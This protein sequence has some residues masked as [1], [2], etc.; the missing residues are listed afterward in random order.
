MKTIIKWIL[1]GIIILMI[2]QC[3]TNTKQQQ[4][5]SNAVVQV[6]EI[7][8]Y[9]IG[10]PLD[11]EIEDQKK[12]DIIFSAIAIYE[13]DINRDGIK[14]KIILD[15]LDR[16]NDPGDFHR[17]RIEFKDT[18]YHFYNSSGW[19]E[20]N[21]SFADE[22]IRDLTSINKIKSD[23]VILNENNNNLLLFVFGYVY[24]SSPGLLTIINL[25]M[26]EPQLILNENY[27]L[28]KYQDTS[29]IFIMSKFFKEDHINKY[30]T[31]ILKGRWLL[32]YSE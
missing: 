19:V 24:A 2:L 13:Y 28:V 29:P 17:V 25:S 6:D 9:L 14:E 11:S 31:L 3:Q 18:C 20:I 10:Q 15:K 4:V 26:K 27:L 16:W 22:Y 21:H 5:V 12:Y 1:D 7:K 23:Y 32:R 8:G 30:D